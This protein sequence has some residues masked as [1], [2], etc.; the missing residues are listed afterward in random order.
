MGLQRSLKGAGYEVNF[1]QEITANS[2]QK[3][4]EK[5]PD[6]VLIDLEVNDSG[7]IDFCYQLKKENDA[8]FFVVVFSKHDEDYI[9]VEAF[10][11]GA[12]DYIIKPINPRVFLK[13]LQALLKRINKTAIQQPKFLNYRNLEVDRDRYKVIKD[14]VELSLPRKEFEIMFLL[15]SYPQRIF[16]RE[17]IFLKVWQSEASNQRIIDVHI[18]K[19]RERLGKSVIK[20]VKGIGYQLS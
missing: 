17:E 9:Q 14:G 16:T 11:A 7:G 12:D 15:I 20:T 8:Q 2:A 1:H 3:V 4:L 6:F 19:I 18:R 13:R 10:K 5:N